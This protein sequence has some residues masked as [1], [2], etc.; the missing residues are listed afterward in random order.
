MVS[1]PHDL[2]KG[3][4]RSEQAMERATWLVLVLAL[5]AFLGVAA[6]VVGRSVDLLSHVE[7]ASTVEG[8]SGVVLARQA[9]LP[10]QGSITAGAQL[11]QGD[12]LQV[13]FG[14]TARL[15]VF[16]GSFVDLLPGTRLRIDRARA[17]RLFGWQ[18][19][20]QLGIETGAAQITVA[21]ASPDARVFELVT[22]AGVARLDAGQYTVRISGDATRI[23]VW[24]GK[25]TML[26]DKQVVDV[27]PGKKIILQGDGK[28][29]LVDVL[30]NVLVNGRFADRLFA[31]PGS[32]GWTFF[33]D[34]AKPD[35]AG[36]VRVE[37][38][39]E[40]G[41]P[42]VA[43]RFTRQSAS[44]THNETG[45]QQVLTRDVSGARQVILDGWL[46]IDDASL[47]GGGYLGSEYPVMIRVKYVT[48]RGGEQV[49]TQGFYYANP[50]GRPA[51][52]GDPKPQ[53]QWVFFEKNL[54][55]L[56]PG[57]LTIEEIQVFAAGHTF[58]SSVADLRLLVD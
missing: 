2:V 43:V 57:A 16:D 27:P 49:W 46:K 8:I 10:A 5:V 6:V 47:S 11:F 55:E 51:G 15:R 42:G 18:S 13:S 35:V 45:I 56:L 41:A 17:A 9:D 7:A 3:P 1:A 29:A 36:D 19:E 22:P 37:V 28:F 31:A 12:Q 34:P 58:D 38:P 44:Q 32:A 23:S 53:R 24:A 52:F 33:E 26:A 40:A 25:V 14:S 50:E 30:E 21:P 39:R 48:L 4:P 20:A 54:V